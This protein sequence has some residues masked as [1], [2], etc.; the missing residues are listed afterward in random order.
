MRATNR[1]LAGR[2]IVVVGYGMCAA[3][4]RVARAGWART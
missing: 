3:G 1:L 2:T 4:R